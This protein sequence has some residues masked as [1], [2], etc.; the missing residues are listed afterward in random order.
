[1]HQPNRREWRILLNFG[2]SITI[3][4]NGCAAKQHGTGFATPPQV[5]AATSVL[6]GA[7]LMNHRYLLFSRNEVTTLH[8]RANTTHAAIWLPIKQFAT[9]QLSVDPLPTVP[10]SPIPPALDELDTYR[11]FGNQLIALAFV[12]V[13]DNDARTCELTK[14]YLLAYATWNQWG[15]AGQR[16]LGHAHMVFGNAIAYNWIHDRLNADEQ[17]LVRVSLAE[18]TNKLY[19]A[20]ISTN[21]R[22]DWLNWWPRSY[23]QNH[24]WVIHS[25]LGLSALALANEDPRAEMWLNH[26][27]AQ[28][29]LVRD[30]LDGIND[31]SWHEGI[32]Y[33]N[34][35]LTM[36][37]PFWISLKQIKGIDLL[38]HAYLK[39]Y[40]L[41]R[42]YNHITTSSGNPQFILANGDFEWSWANGFQSQGILTF[43]AAD[44]RDGHA[45]W[46]AQQLV[47]IPRRVSVWATPWNV[48]EFL[49]FDPSVA[50]ISPDTLPRSYTFKDSESVIWR[51]GWNKDDL[52][53]GFKSGAPGGRFAFDTFTQEIYPWNAPCPKTDCSLNTGHDH[54]DTNTFSIFKSGQWLAPETVKNDGKDTLLHNTILIDGNG[55]FTPSEADGFK[56]PSI[57]AGTDGRLQATVNTPTFDYLAAD[58]TKRYRDIAG[59]TAVKRYVIFV[60][61]GYLVMLDHLS[62]TSA[63]DY[64]WVSHFDQNVTIEGNWIRGNSP[65]QQILGIGA[66]SPQPTHY[67][68][69]HDGQP[70]VHEQVDQSVDDARFVHVLYP[71]NTSDWANRPII[72]LA[73]DNN[74]AIAVQVHARD[75]SH[76]DE[77]LLTYGIAPYVAGSPLTSTSISTYR[78][79]GSAAVITRGPNAELRKI[80]LH[81]ATYLKDRVLGQRLV[82]RLDP[83][84][85]IEITYDGNNIDIYGDV[86]AGLM[87]YAPYAQSL[88]V[89]GQARS[90][91]RSGNVITLK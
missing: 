89:N 47:P 86:Q 68:T 3:L 55:Q 4:L 28:M 34:Y 20:T 2:I 30:L 67:I 66:I 19:E 83:R 22:A 52:V 44:Q 32:P 41:W 87:I 77:I 31:G 14:R 8:Q 33:Q 48:F 43:I 6:P 80:F 13:V 29:T 61:P 79:D 69:G 88:T 26:A 64:A 27:V 23:A 91:S 12:C 1:M 15:E 73:E 49:Y 58:A 70:F 62:A 76:S 7:P 35:A 57:F 38:P 90:F 74:S 71:S 53:F 5:S 39:N 56:E 18:W 37:L 42:I 10:V 46:M 36:A 85:A 63:H 78:Y 40:V 81:G 21:Y 50:A 84:S 24:H 59:L 11:N 45:Q 17:Q 54:N 60:R 65:D 82:E 72:S 51:T 16:G 9:S 25:A 75:G